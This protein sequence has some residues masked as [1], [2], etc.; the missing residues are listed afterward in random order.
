[1]PARW[2]SSQRP[3]LVRTVWVDGARHAILS[4]DDPAAHGPPAVRCCRSAPGGGG[5][6]SP[7]VATRTV[8][9]V[10]AGGRRLLRVSFLLGPEPPQGPAPPPL[11][12]HGARGHPRRRWPPASRR[13]R[14]CGRPFV[15]LGPPPS[16]SSSDCGGEQLA[17]PLSERVLRWL[18]LAG[19]DA[20][21]PPS[22]PLPPQQPPP[23]PPPLP[24][25]PR[26]LRTPRRVVRTVSLEAS[27]PS[28]PPP[29]SPP[30]SPLP[31][32]PP[33]PEP[34]QKAGQCRPQLH[35]FVPTLP[36]DCDTLSCH[37]DS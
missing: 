10:A 22:P 9:A 35:V 14:C 12:P 2:A 17:G 19:R 21:A 34:E 28:P 18:H 33:S 27:P 3:L 6:S 26:P 11:H 16:P 31:S 25:S 1:M 13:P 4:A 7:A 30:S 15:P 24:A 8:A 37:S 36:R 32:P 29:P 5:T 20:P 23:L